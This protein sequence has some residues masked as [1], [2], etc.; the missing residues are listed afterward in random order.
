M[1]KDELIAL[2]ADESQVEQHEEEM[3]SFSA[4]IDWAKPNGLVIMLALSGSGP[5]QEPD[6]S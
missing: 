3:D 4:V 1:L 2:D 6:A 5:L